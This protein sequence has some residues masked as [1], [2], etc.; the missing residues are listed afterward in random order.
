MIPIKDKHQG[1]LRKKILR[2]VQQC[3]TEFS[4]SSNVCGNYIE[5]LITGSL[6]NFEYELV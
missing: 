4:I 1:I 3:W 5:C 6:L 2:E